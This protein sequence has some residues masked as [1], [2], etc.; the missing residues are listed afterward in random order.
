MAMQW[1]TIRIP[2]HVAERLERLAIEVAEDLMKIGSGC[3]GTA[4]LFEFVMLQT[5]RKTAPPDYPGKEVPH[6]AAY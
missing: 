3:Q 2:A 1:T 6:A 5:R 4:E